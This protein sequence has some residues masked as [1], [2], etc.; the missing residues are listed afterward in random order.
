MP[1]RFELGD[2]RGAEQF[3]VLEDPFVRQRAELYIT[4]QLIDTDLVVAEDLLEAL[5]G[6]PAL[7]QMWIALRGDAP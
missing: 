6:C 1:T 4:E 5:L 3:E 2:D 7:P